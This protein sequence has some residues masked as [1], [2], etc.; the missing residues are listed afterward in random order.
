VYKQLIVS[1]LSST[2]YRE[3][4]VFMG[5]KIVG[6]TG[7]V[8]IAIL[9]YSVVVSSLTETPESNQLNS[10]LPNICAGV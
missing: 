8:T 5:K 6:A 4:V 3:I 10:L 9:S 7:L 1:C 2:T